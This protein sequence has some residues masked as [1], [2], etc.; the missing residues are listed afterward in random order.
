M[1]RA[2]S[3]DAAAPA[4]EVLGLVLVGGL[5]KRGGTLELLEAV[6]LLADEGGVRLRRLHPRRFQRL[7][8]SPL[9]EAGLRQIAGEDDEDGP[10]LHP[11]AHPD[12]DLRDRPSDGRGHRPLLARHHPADHRHGLG[13]R[14]LPDG[15]H[16]DQGRGPAAALRGRR[17]RSVQ[18][19]HEN[20]D[21]TRTGASHAIAVSARMGRAF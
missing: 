3:A 13:D 7:V 4:H 1:V 9:V 11:V 6:E 2:S 8:R 15:V 10:H 21:D 12:R 20:A 16:L 19:K 17:G 14:L 18:R 5:G